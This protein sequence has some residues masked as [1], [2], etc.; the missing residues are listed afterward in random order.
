M[1]TREIG[2]AHDGGRL[3][4]FLARHEPKLTRSR[5]KRL[6]DSG[7]ILINGQVPKV[8]QRLHP[9]DRVVIT[10]P[11]PAP[12]ELE[13]Q[14]IPIPVMFQDH[15]LIVVDKPAG[16][17]VHPGPGHPN[18]TLVNALLAL[19]PDISGIG[20]YLRPGI[21]HRLD[22]DTSGLMV[23]AKTDAAHLDI[24]RQIKERRVRKGYLALVRGRLEPD[25]GTIEAPVGRH[26]VHRKRMAVVN[27]GKEAKTS[28][29]VI[30]YLPEASFLEVFPETGRTHQIRVHFASLGHPLIGDGL[31]GRK[32]SFLDRHFLHAHL[33]G[34]THPTRGESLEFTSPLPQD[35]RQTLGW[36]E[37]SSLSRIE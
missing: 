17:S 14:E 22:K 30:R 34:F 8:S 29:H 12:I 13:A 26:P 7:H 31:Y 3:D 25:K 28:Y 18:H 24:S 16:L 5:I 15:D 33:L 21:V 2:I 10:V 19:C 1:V 11:P 23:V 9:G 35:L 32:H 36:L 6:I 4:L 27:G 20:G 37:E